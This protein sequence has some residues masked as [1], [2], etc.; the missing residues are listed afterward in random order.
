MEENCSKYLNIDFMIVD[1]LTLSSATYINVTV[2]SDVV[3]KD[4]RCG[5]KQQYPGETHVSE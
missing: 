1:V 3:V 2:G 5:R 4:H